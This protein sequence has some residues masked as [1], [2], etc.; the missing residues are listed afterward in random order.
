MDIWGQF[1][2]LALGGID[3]PDYQGGLIQYQ[4]PLVQSYHACNQY[5]ILVLVTGIQTATR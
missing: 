2:P 1:A 3:A 4:V 5:Q